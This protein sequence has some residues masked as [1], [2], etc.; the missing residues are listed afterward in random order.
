M[1]AAAAQFA[2]GAPLL[3]REFPT[4]GT[5]GEDGKP[6]GGAAAL[7]FRT[8]TMAPFLDQAEK[9][10]DALAEQVNAQNAAQLEKHKW[11]LAGSAAQPFSG[12]TEKLLSR[13]DGASAY[14]VALRR[15]AATVHDNAGAA[16]R[17]NA[18]RAADYGSARLHLM[19]Q[20][21]HFGIAWPPDRWPSPTPPAPRKLKRTAQAW[22]L[23]A[24]RMPAAHGAAPD[25]PTAVVVRAPA[26]PVGDEA[27]APMPRT[28]HHV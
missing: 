6:I 27:A 18:Q 9:I 7:E 14:S 13:E 10:A 5:I 12:G 25:A 1:L 19:T 3:Q 16:L 24:P 23:V 8:I 20:P 22:P 2:C 15:M 17:A 4:A 26:P 11:R 28:V 21:P